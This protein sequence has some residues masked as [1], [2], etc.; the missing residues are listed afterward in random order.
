MEDTNEEYL[1]KWNSHHAELV[2]EF[3]DLCKVTFNIFIFNSVYLRYWTKSNYKFKKYVFSYLER[4]IHRCYNISWR[5]NVWGSQID[6]FCLF[7]ILSISSKPIPLP[8]SSHL[9]KWRISRPCCHSSQIHV[10]WTNCGQ[11]RG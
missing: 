6:P 4:R 8:S 9:S 5:W 10:C 3:L 2:S 1:L 11:E 7:S